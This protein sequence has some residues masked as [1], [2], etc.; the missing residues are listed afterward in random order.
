[1]H[2]IPDFDKKWQVIGSNKPH[3]ESQFLYVFFDFDFLFER[4]EMPGSKT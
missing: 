3:R 2:G 4:L 1:L